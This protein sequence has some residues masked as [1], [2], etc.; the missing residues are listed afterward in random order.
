[1]SEKV[2]QMKRRRQSLIIDQSPASF[3]LEYEVLLY[4]KN[5]LN[6]ETESLSTLVSSSKMKIRSSL[7]SYTNLIRNLNVSD[8]IETPWEREMKRSRMWRKV[9]EQDYILRYIDISYKQLEDELDELEEYRLDVIYQSSYM[10]LNMLTFYEEFI[11]LRECEATEY[12]L[13]EKV[14]KKLNERTAIMLKVAITSNLNACNNLLISAF[15]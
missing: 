14:N 12:A 6:D 15:T 4:D 2:Q 11:I 8:A 1:M 3:D 5:D 9:Y 10:N 13:E 7:P